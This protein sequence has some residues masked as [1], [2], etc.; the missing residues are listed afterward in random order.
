MIGA[1][2]RVGG[3]VGGA[4]GRVATTELPRITLAGLLTG[5]VPVDEEQHAGCRGNHEE[6]DDRPSNLG[7]RRDQLCGLGDPGL[8]IDIGL[9]D[10]GKYWRRVEHDEARDGNTSGENASTKRAQVTGWGVRVS[11]HQV[12]W[13]SGPA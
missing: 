11:R 6:P 3:F 8:R 9:D 10:L 12:A 2:P 7:A 1:R 13:V 5:H 4:P